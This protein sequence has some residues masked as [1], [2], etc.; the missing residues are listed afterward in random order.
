MSHRD[1]PRLALNNITAG[2]R[3]PSE[4]SGGPSDIEGKTTR[5]GASECGQR[6]SFNRT[7]QAG[8]L[9][10]IQGVVASSLNCF[11]KWR[12]ASSN[13]WT[14][15][16]ESRCSNLPSRS[17][18]TPLPSHSLYISILHV[19]WDILGEK[20]LHVITVPHPHF[21]DA[22]TAMLCITGPSGGHCCTNIIV[23]NCPHRTVERNVFGLQRGARGRT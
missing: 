14:D 11:A 19:S 9:D 1:K 3:E 13:G 20:N 6:T 21:V 15:Q 23:R 7:R 4:W 22:S 5:V 18:V 10:E 8:H 17:H 2:V 12:L 16:C